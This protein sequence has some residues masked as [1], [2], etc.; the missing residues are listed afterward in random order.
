MAYFSWCFKIWGR[1]AR[2]KAI[3]MITHRN[4]IA[5]SVLL[6]GCSFPNRVSWGFENECLNF[7]QTTVDLHLYIR[8]VI[9]S[10]WEKAISLL[11]AES[12]K[13]LFFC[14]S[15]LFV[16]SSNKLRLELSAAWR[17]LC[18]LCFVT[19]E[20]IVEGWPGEESVSLQRFPQRRGLSDLKGKW[21]QALH[22]VT[23][24]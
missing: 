22:R 5:S 1:R 11:R 17:G 16:L 12:L 8:Q 24:D 9:Q 3:G 23:L 19:S 7:S 14:W 2:L 18:Q 4:T 15:H 6:P 20:V 21:W 10:Y 13:D